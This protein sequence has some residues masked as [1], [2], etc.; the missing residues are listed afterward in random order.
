MHGTRLRLRSL[1][2]ESTRGMTS[3]SKNDEQLGQLG[4]DVDVDTTLVIQ[5]LKIELLEVH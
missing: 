2:L 1:Q 5:C 4:R 3:F